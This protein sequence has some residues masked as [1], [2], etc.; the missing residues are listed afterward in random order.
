MDTK[1]RQA[2]MDVDAYIPELDALQIQK[3]PRFSRPLFRKPSPNDR[4]L[5]ASIAAIKIR[6]W[7][8]P[9]LPLTLL[10]TTCVSLSSSGGDSV[11]A[12]AS[13]GRH[14]AQAREDEQRR[15]ERGEQQAPAPQ[16]PTVLPPPAPVDYVVFMQDLVQAMQTQ[17][18]NQAALQAQL[19]AQAPAPVPQEYGHGGPSIM[20]RFKRMAPPSFKGESQPLLAKSWMRKVEKIFWAIRCVEEDQVSL[21]TY[22]LQFPNP[23]P[24]L[25]EKVGFLV[26]LP[27]R[28]QQRPSSFRSAT[29]TAI[30]SRSVMTVAVLSRSMTMAA[31]LLP[32]YDDSGHP[33]PI[34]DDGSHLLSFGD[35]GSI[36]PS[37]F[38][39]SPSTL[40]SLSPSLIRMK[41]DP[42][43]PPFQPPGSCTSLSFTLSHAHEGYQRSQ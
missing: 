36:S 14:G 35:D 33:F 31:I 16:G 15:E 28:R 41:G 10:A 11:H 22:M 29:T 5:M 26:P 30:P 2:A 6:A 27:D 4:N 38:C 18:Q 23:H 21:A 40:C 19:Q 43:A 1:P 32:I 34:G 17:A 13:R 39:I 12:M 24:R 8:Q 42:L 7:R 37:R 25:E 9:L 3:R 20:E